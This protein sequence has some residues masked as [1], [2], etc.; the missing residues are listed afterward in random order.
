MNLQNGGEFLAVCL[1]LFSRLFLTTGDV[2]A[3]GSKTYHVLYRHILET[4]ADE[5][6]ALD[7]DLE[8]AE[9]EEEEAS[10]GCDLKV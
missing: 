8:E 10:C 6:A 4:A 9:E 5:E 1:A 7:E 2:S 3:H